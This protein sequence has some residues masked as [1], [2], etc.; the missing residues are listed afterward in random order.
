MP[1]L[2]QTNEV[3][4][5]SPQA[6]LGSGVNLLELA[7][8]LGNVSLACEMAGVSRSRFYKLKAQ[9][10]QATTPA[11]IHPPR[12]RQLSAEKALQEASIL[13]HTEA[14]PAQSYLRLSLTMSAAGERASPAEIRTVWERRGLSVRKQ[15]Q[16]WANRN[17]PVDAKTQAE[18]DRAARFQALFESLGE[19]KPLE[20]RAP[21]GLLVQG[22]CFY[23]KL[24]TRGKVY[25]V[26]AIDVFSGYVFAGLYKEK[27]HLATFDLLH[28]SAM[29]HLMLLGFRIKKVMTGTGR[30]FLKPI[31][32][33]QFDSY[34]YCRNIEHLHT[35]SE[36]PRMNGMVR[37]F[38][39]RVRQ[40]LV[41]PL[42]R[43]GQLDQGQM[44]IGDLARYVDAH[45]TQNPSESPHA[46]GRTPERMMLDA[47]PAHR[48]GQRTYPISPTDST[49]QF[50]DTLHWEDPL[51]RSWE[52]MMLRG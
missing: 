38:H 13:A 32:P 45:N 33:T 42:I 2:K 23:C 46:M 22:A 37:R 5:G 17:A 20:T 10:E 51:S 48:K 41:V 44:L 36:S 4:D 18:R 8:R 12:T 39:R 1:G 25:L 28:F 19:P 11:A 15:R 43:N 29:R 3:I 7:A 34:L 50:Y 52:G 6:I 27:S 24:D 26:T 40:A 21:G 14:N 49:L 16:S 30:E 47:I 35:N 9:A 31:L